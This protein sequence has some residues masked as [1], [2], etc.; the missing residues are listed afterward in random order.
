MVLHRG[1]VQPPGL[2]PWPTAS[3]ALA[4]AVA[5]DGTVDPPIASGWSDDGG[6]SG[7]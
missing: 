5:E 2:P 1:S 7:T 6:G 3:A 4:R